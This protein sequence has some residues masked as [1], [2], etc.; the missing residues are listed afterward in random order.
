MA[1]GQQSHH[2]LLLDEFNVV[3]N[4]PHGA[5]LN[6]LS[7]YCWSYLVKLVSLVFTYALLAKVAISFFSAGSVVSI[8]WPGSGLAL[9]ALLLGGKKYW[10]G[11]FIGEFVGVI[12]CGTS[13][14]ISAFVALGNT[15]EALAGVWLLSRN[16]SFDP[17]LK[18][19]RNY[20]SLGIVGILSACVSALIGTG[21]LLMSELLALHAAVSTFLSWWQGDIL[22]IMLVT[23][24]IL[25]WRQL[26]WDWCKRDRILETIACFGV[27][28]LFGQIVFLGWFNDWLG[29]MPVFWIFPFVVW[30]AVRFGRH[31]SLLVIFITAVQGLL[32]LIRHVGFF[33]TTFPGTELVA[34]WFYTLILSAIGITLALII[35][36]NDQTKQTLSL[37]EEKLRTM[38][39][40]SPIGMT[41][42]SMDGRYI[43]ANKALLDMV[44]YSLEELNSLTYWH[45]TP[46]EYEA[47]EDQQLAMLHNTR[48]YGPYEKEYVHKNGHRVAIRLNGILINGSDGE[49]YIWSTIEDITESKQAEYALQHNEKLFRT[50]LDTLPI[51]IWIIDAK[52]KILRGNEAGQKIWAGAKYVGIEQ[53]GEYQGW[54]SDTGERI[55]SDEWAAARAIT[56][57]EISLDEVI[58]IECFDGTCKTILNSAI[59]LRDGNQ[60]I[61]GAIIVNQDISERRQAEDA[62]QLAA[63]VYQNSSEAMMVTDAHDIIIAI[64]P[65]FTQLTGYTQDEV[66][67][68]NPS[69]RS[70]GRHDEAFYQNMWNEIDATG[71]WQGEIWNR[72]K[73]GD[74]CAEWLSVNT[75]FNQDGSVHRRVALF[76][77]ITQKKAADDL[78]W[79]QANFDSLTGLPNRRMFHDRLEQEIKKA[80]CKNL[81]LALLFL[82]LDRFK[83]INDSLGHSVGD[84][85][86]KEVAQRL[87]NCTRE[88]D[89]Q[90]RLSG[91][92]FTIILSEL[93]DL[94]V[95]ETIAERILTD[96]SRPFTL[97]AEI[98]YISVSIGITIYPENATD[99]EELVKCA[100]QAMYYAKNQGRNRYSFF[101]LSM[102]E[103]VQKRMKLANELHVALAEQQFGVVYQ[104]IVELA[105]GH[106]G[107]AEALLRWYHPILGQ[108]NPG[109]F[110]SIAEDTGM[111][112]EIGEWVFHQAV[113]QVKQWR[114]V[115]YSEFQISVNKS[116]RQFL[117]E[118]AHYE[119]WP[120]Q[121]KRFGLPGQSIV[122]EITEGM[123]L[124]NS[125]F[126][127]N[128]LFSFRDNGMQVSLDD[129]GTG[130][131]SLS[132]LRKFDIDY[133]KIDQSFVRNLDADSEDLVLCEAIIVMA[134]KLGIKVIAEG[135]ETTEQCD[136][137]MAAG[138]DYGQGYLFSRP[139]P[140]Q[141]FEKLFAVNKTVHSG[142]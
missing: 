39:E 17:A 141:E 68:K 76:Y 102:Q 33:G 109:E 2:K 58:D 131:S 8:V 16:H 105:T 41:R 108:I 88:I 64:N 25:V 111:I 74:V 57:G 51:G 118:N 101:N 137:L 72:H 126:I 22:G 69:I 49:N 65:A 85:L 38:F 54:W 142:L 133:L 96:L 117:D 129:F 77:D 18:H 110:I 73:S 43:E 89:T 13:P 28:W 90:A 21:T 56:K 132:Y 19:P 79:Q 123:L 20:L 119:A 140:A 3:Q 93:D 55:K 27:A 47:Q 60:Q 83:E 75:I 66:I 37:S 80:H 127:K 70:S 103:A 4:F 5:S 40:M 136:L 114:S 81:H 78:I 121:L 84:R 24:F 139:V 11:I 44:G 42:N 107:K 106:I 86:L 135:I 95:V 120:D 71:C 124:D 125:G 99:S 138:C 59:P 113:H 67:G 97:G 6:R 91:D 128:K 63:L 50:V 52:G 134:H 48:R 36:E 30:S 26:P 98:I 130:Y 34:F 35:Y 61:T 32:G 94:S 23:P 14:G 46:K 15:L 122:V 53:Y 1:S 115:Y 12:L 104:P 7:I 100:D 82:D 87:N 45:L 9:A 116:P 31:G 29:A 112:I 10:P 92:E 62:V